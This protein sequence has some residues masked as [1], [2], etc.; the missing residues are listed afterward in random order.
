[1]GTKTWIETFLEEPS[2]LYYVQIDMEFILDTFNSYGLR[3]KMTKFR[4]AQDLLIY[5]TMLQKGDI[6]TIHRQASVLYGL[7]HQRFLSMGEGLR[8]IRQ[9]YK[10]GVFPRCPRV[11][12]KGTECLPYGITDQ[13]GEHRI[14]MYCPCCNDVYNVKDLRFALVDGAYFGPSYVHLYM[15][16]WPSPGQNR[17]RYVPN[18]F[19]FAICNEADVVVASEGGD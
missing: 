3:E 17:K 10:Q 15:Q 19:G 6:R 1:M 8:A 13:P 18:I 4:E 12:C 16:S 11:Y 14:N 7:I 5:N 9:K 2:S